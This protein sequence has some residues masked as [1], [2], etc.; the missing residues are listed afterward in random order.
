MIAAKTQTIP[1]TSRSSRLSL[2]TS[3]TL[4]SEER[5]AA[6]ER[7]ALA[8]TAPRVLL[9]LAL[10]R[11]TRPVDLARAVVLARAE[12]FLR[13]AVAVRFFVAWAKTSPGGVVSNGGYTRPKGS[14]GLPGASEKCSR[15]IVS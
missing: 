3:C 1:P 11:A 5:V 15:P 8:D 10:P 12:V 6:E 2:F 9:L 13:R 14:K 7:A 4:A